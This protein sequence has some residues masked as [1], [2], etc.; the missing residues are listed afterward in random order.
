MSSETKYKLKTGIMITIVLALVNL[1]AVPA[2]N[3]AINT[4]EDV[5]VLKSEIPVIR[6]QLKEIKELINEIR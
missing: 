5:A 4:V 6:E 3:R 2:V 1:F